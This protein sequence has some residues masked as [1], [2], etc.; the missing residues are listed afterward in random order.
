MGAL[1]KDDKGRV[2]LSR[3][4]PLDFAKPVSPPS[5]QKPNRISS[6]IDRHDSPMQ[7]SSLR[8]TIRIQHEASRSLIGRESKGEEST[9]TC[10][11]SAQRLSSAIDRPSSAQGTEPAIS[12][13]S[14]KRTSLRFSFQRGNPIARLRKASCFKKRRN[15]SL[16]KPKTEPN[17]SVAEESGDACSSTTKRKGKITPKDYVLAER[18]RVDEIKT[19]IESKQYDEALSNLMSD[20][21]ADFH[22]FNKVKSEVLGK[23]HDDAFSRRHG[24]LFERHPP[25]EAPNTCIWSG[26]ND[27][28]HPLRC[29]NKCLCHPVEKVTDPLGVERPKQL[30]HC[31]YHVKYCVNT[32]H[33]RVPMKIRTENEMAL[34]NECFLLRNGQ[35]PKGLLRVPGTKRKRD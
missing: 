1:H 13:S 24:K 33:H 2:S 7:P 29:H 8:S 6:L 26:A 25:V 23:Q 27:F 3:A 30:D 15:T 9:R 21:D 4:L 22:Y 19:M 32:D 20:T 10:P 14:E 17:D 12:N 11:S 16:R 18:E 34:C 28:G 31:V 5:H 35:P